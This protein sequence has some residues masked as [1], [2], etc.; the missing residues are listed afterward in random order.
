MTA[1]L[2]DGAQDDGCARDHRGLDCPRGM[3]AFKAGFVASERN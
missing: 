2:T 1:P 3:L